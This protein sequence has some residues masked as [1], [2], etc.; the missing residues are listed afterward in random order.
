MNRR[1]R[2]STIAII[3]CLPQILLLLVAI[4]LMASCGGIGW[5]VET[6]TKA[7]ETGTIQEL[8]VKRFSNEGTDQFMVVIKKDSD[9][10]VEVFQNTDSLWNWKWDSADVN[11]NLKE[12]ER[13]RIYVYGW[14]RP[15]FSW[16]RNIT[17]SKNCHRSS[18]GKASQLLRGFFYLFQNEINQ[19]PWHDHR[20]IRLPLHPL[21]YSLVV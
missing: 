12:G 21:T 16:F 20:L 18:A 15:M 6:Q 11:A 2:G 14:R 8:Y 9:G 5:F 10:E 4:I 17:K 7:V 19:S 1:F 13:V 3:G